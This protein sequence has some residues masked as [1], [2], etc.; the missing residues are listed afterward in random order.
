[1]F[2]HYKQ[3]LISRSLFFKRIIT[4]II[5]SFTLLFVT[6][7]IGALIFHYLGGF[8]WVDSILNAVSVMMG[9]SIIGTLNN[10]VLKLLIS[11]YAVLSGIIFFSVLMILFSP[12]I[13][14]FLHRFH[15]DI[16]V[17]K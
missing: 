3:P 7:F 17:K 5:I 13:H 16:E 15:L 10:S 8:S 11:F 14:R 6:N 9:I 1:M 2:E 12:V 4:C